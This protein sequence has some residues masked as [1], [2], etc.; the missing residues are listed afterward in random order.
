MHAHIK[1]AAITTAATSATIE[2]IFSVA[3][4]TSTVKMIHGISTMKMPLPPALGSAL[5]VWFDGIEVSF[6]LT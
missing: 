1:G 2:P 4:E 3:C 5:C 6:R